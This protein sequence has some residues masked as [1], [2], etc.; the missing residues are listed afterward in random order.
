MLCS[1]SWH[2][3]SRSKIF[4]KVRWPVRPISNDFFKV[5]KKTRVS[6][7]SWPLHAI[8]RS[9]QLQIKYKTIAGPQNYL[10]TPLIQHVKY[11]LLQEVL[12]YSLFTT[13][14]IHASWHRLPN[15]RNGGRTVRYDTPLTVDLVIWPTSGHVK[16]L[17]HPTAISAPA[18]I[19]NSQMTHRLRSYRA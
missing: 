1:K 14:R 16:E 12:K 19:I 6:K 13:H 4:I 3:P 9:R 5:R 7:P 15:R 18:I 8:A 17:T 2:V 11:V 10:R